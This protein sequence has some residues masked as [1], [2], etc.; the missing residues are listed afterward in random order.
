V[1]IVK[2]VKQSSQPTPPRNNCNYWRSA[3]CVFACC[4]APLKCFRSL[5]F[6]YSLLQFHKNWS[7]SIDS[8]TKP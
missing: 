5:S 4:Y 3:D 7:S 8:P 6:R 1:K 2:P